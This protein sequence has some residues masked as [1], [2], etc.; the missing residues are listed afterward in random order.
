MTIQQLYYAI[1]I[2]DCG[3]MNK[4]SKKQ[5]ISGII[6]IRRCF[7]FSVQLF[8]IMLSRISVNLS[9]SSSVVR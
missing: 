1:T 6:K 7:A 2:A 4:A 3:S 9:S 8:L 5:N